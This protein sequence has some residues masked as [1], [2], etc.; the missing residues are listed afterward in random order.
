[1][2]QLGAWGVDVAIPSVDCCNER[3][4]AKAIASVERL[5]EDHPVRE[6]AASLEQ[7]LQRTT[8]KAARNGRFGQVEYRR[9]QVEVLD[10]IRHPASATDVAFLLDDERYMNRLIVQKQSMSL[11]A[12]IAESLP[13]IGQQH[14]CRAVVQLMRFQV[15]HK[16]PDNLVDAGDL[17]VVRRGA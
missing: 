10:G 14:D 4:A 15:V 11:L 12:V 6:T 3:A 13:V 9:D 7:W 17:I 2:V 16:A 8:A 1:V 5:S